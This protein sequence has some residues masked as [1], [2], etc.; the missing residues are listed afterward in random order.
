MQGGQLGRS[1]DCR[2]GDCTVPSL[3]WFYR[4][5]AFGAGTW[6]QKVSVRVSVSCNITDSQCF[7]YMTAPYY[8]WKC[9]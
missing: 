8:C 7:R 4:V 3:S 2:C 9:G 1:I 6:G 5:N